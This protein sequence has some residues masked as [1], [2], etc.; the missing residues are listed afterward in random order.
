MKKKNQGSTLIE[1]IVA[2]GIVALVMTSVV[3]V[4]TVSVRNSAQ[5]KA[6]G[7]ATKYS[8]EAMEFFR[9]QRTQLGW[10]SFVKVFQDDGSTI[11]YCLTAIPADSVAFET[12]QGGDCAPTAFVDSRNIFQRHAEVQVVSSDQVNVTVQVT[13]L[14]GEVNRESHITQEFRRSLTQ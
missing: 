12:L 9:R 7:I 2:T 4:V 1:I 3:A 13:W 10:E 11:D 5:A 8:Q 14:D 6:K